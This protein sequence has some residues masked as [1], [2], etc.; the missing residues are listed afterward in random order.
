[1]RL[2]FTSFLIFLFLLFFICFTLVYIRELSLIRKKHIDAESHRDQMKFELLEICNTSEESKIE[3]LKKQES[4]RIKELIIKRNEFEEKFSVLTV[5]IIELKLDIIRL[6]DFLSS[7][8]DIIKISEIKVIEKIDKLNTFEID[9]IKYSNIADNKKIE[10]NQILELNIEREKKK[11]ILVDNI[12][13]LRE[14][15]KE[16]IDNLEQIFIKYNQNEFC[17]K[18]SLNKFWNKSK[19]ERNKNSIK[20]GNMLGTA[21]KEGRRKG[22]SMEEDKINYKKKKNEDR[23][24][25]KLGRRMRKKR[26]IEN[27]DEEKEE[28]E[29]EKEEEKD[30]KEIY[31][32]KLHT[33]NQKVE[34]KMVRVDIVKDSSD[35]VEDSTD[36]VEESSESLENSTDL[37]EDST[38]IVGMPYAFIE[39]MEL[40]RE[41]TERELIDMIGETSTEDM[42]RDIEK[43]MDKSR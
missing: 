7:I 32:R 4:I 37:V 16:K 35:L 31:K 3:I 20:N 12:E 17:E 21:R 2:L 23:E 15:L 39:S 43:Y 18:Y 40:D 14:N 30:G 8:N 33:K 34:N 25:S 28:K 5:S 24:K 29:E 1:M 38:Y 27:S 26:E 9:L 42:N 36:L 13:V 6:K 22:T 41:K 19:K 10:L 11:N